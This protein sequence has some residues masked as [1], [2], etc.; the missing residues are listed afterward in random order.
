MHYGSLVFGTTLTVTLS[1]ATVTDVRARTIPN[2]AP[3]VITV[4]W[5]LHLPLEGGWDKVPVDL[6]GAASVF[7]VGF[8]SW[9]CGLLGGGDVK[10]LTALAL[11][12]GGPMLVPFIVLTALAGGALAVVWLAMRSLRTLLPVPAL[13]A[14]GRLG[15][16]VPRAEPTTLP[17]G[18]AIGLAGFWL[19][20]HLF[21]FSR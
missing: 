16:E 18:V 21:W 9:R 10:L 8:A 12:A 6:I 1:W 13:I 5:L 3:A 2:L 14:L 4:L 11:W 7:A 19:V 20:Y 15:V 17:Y